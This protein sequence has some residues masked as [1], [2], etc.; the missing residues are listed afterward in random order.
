MSTKY[1]SILFL[2][3]AGCGKD[4]PPTVAPPTGS[5]VAVDDNTRIRGLWLAVSLRREEGMPE[6]APNSSSIRFEN[7][8]Y[9]MDI[10]DH[11][12]AG[13]YTLIP[14]TNPK[15][16]DLA[17]NEGSLR[18]GLYT[19]DGDRLVVCMPDEKDQPRPMELKAS[20]E[21]PRTSVMTFMRS[22]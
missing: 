6:E 12:E 3:L 15:Q 20:A 11:N 22:K 4:A 1:S 14:G 16:I 7:G 13:R 19:L 9:S 10:P 21:E 17:T 18:R 8:G 5:A 2:L